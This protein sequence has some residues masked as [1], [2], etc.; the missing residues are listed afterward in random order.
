MRRAGGRG[1]C[2]VRRAGLRRRP[3]PGRSRRRRA[4]GPRPCW[5]TGLVRDGRGPAGGGGRRARAR[6]S[7]STATTCSATLCARFGLEVRDT[8]M[9]YYVREPR[10]GIGATADGAHRRVGAARGRR[11]RAGDRRPRGARRSATSSPGVREAL[12]ARIEMSCAAPLATLSADVITHVASVAPLRSARVAGGNQQVA[13]RLAAE[14][15]SVVHLRTPVLGVSHS[16][17]GRRGRDGRRRGR[18]RPRG[19]RGAAA[20][21]HRPRRTTPSCRRGSRTRWAGSSTA[22]RPSSRCRCSR[23]PAR[24]RSWP[25]RTATGRGRW[26]APGRPV[27]RARPWSLP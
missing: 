14:L 3:G 19:A 10:G 7:S 13:A 27:D 15:G 5:G 22:M 4:R 18:G 20:G 11:D 12:E 21:P 17:I 9:S 25:R 2:R 26:P 16:D 23:R 6:S 24:R 8:G 1:R